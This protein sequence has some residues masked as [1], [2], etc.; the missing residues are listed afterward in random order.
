MNREYTLEYIKLVTQYM[1]LMSDIT[2]GM[3]S[4]F[5]NQIVMSWG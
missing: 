2:F 5:L 1:E 4:S 3:S